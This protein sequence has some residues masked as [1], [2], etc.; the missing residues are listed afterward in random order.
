MIDKHSQLRPGMTWLQMDIR[1]L[2][3]EDG[4]FDVA[5]DKGRSR[6]VSPFRSRFRPELT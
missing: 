2:K 6:L 1:D 3:F 4:S 5:L